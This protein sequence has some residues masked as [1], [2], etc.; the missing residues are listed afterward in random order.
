MAYK[1][2]LQKVPVF[3]RYCQEEEL[4]VRH[5]YA[6]PLSNEEHHIQSVQQQG[7][8]KG[9]RQC[10]YGVDLEVG[11]GIVCPGRGQVRHWE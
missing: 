3:P 2:K 11:C 10:S 6:C 5:G 8:Q 4:C 7:S 1:F 9:Y